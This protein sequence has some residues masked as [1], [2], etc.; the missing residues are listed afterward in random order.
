MMM[1]EHIYSYMFT[2]VGL[3]VNKY[4]TIRS[5]VA[6]LDKQYKAVNNFSINWSTDHFDNLI[7]SIFNKSSTKL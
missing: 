5:R 7:L 1:N 6:R 4:V 3:H 2:F